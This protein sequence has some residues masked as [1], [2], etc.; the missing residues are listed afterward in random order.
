VLAP[1]AD[2]VDMFLEPGRDHGGRLVGSASA[3]QA[4][5]AGTVFQ[6]TVT[7]PTGKTTLYVHARWVASGQEQVLTLPVIVS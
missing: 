3:V 5:E 2:R 7:A 4:R 6:A 1:G